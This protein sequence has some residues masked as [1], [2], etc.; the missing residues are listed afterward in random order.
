MLAVAAGKP[1]PTFDVRRS[2]PGSEPVLDPSKS[3]LRRCPR[4]ADATAVIDTGGKFLDP[5]DAGATAELLATDCV[6]C[7]VARPDRTA[8]C[9][10]L[11]NRL[12]TGDLGR[13]GASGGVIDRYGCTCDRSNSDDFSF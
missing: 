9:R 3:I 1:G 8:P 7:P 11:S 13:T 6:A 4:V 2:K 10:K 5:A 12:L